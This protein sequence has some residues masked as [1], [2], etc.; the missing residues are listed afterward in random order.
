M[1]NSQE[2]EIDFSWQSPASAREVAFSLEQ[3]LTA[4]IPH[5]GGNNVDLAWEATHQ[6]QKMRVRIVVEL[7]E[8]FK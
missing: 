3:S 8:E 6:H 5:I 7:V 4:A 2:L 1:S